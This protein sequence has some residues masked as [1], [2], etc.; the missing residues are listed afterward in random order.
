M[1][2]A[3]SSM[4]LEMSDE[5]WHIYDP[6]DWRP[7][8]ADVSYFEYSDFLFS[9]QPSLDQMQ[10]LHIVEYEQHCAIAWVFM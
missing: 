1:Y 4:R 5:Q 3:F 9:A 2:A 7:C 10:F 8:E 6:K